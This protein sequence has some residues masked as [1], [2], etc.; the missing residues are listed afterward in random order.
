MPL[1]D[2][3]RAR[4]LARF[5]GMRGRALTL[6]FVPMGP[7]VEASN[8]AELQEAADAALVA[9]TLDQPAN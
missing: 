1:S 3:E 2:E 5:R 9:A 8:P 4:A 7:T 6:N